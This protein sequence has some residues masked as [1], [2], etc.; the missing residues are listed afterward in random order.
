MINRESRDVLAECVRLYLVGEVSPEELYDLADRYLTCND[1]AIENFAEFLTFDIFEQGLGFAPCEFSKSVWD[2]IQRYLL[3]LD[4]DFQ[5]QE[6]STFIWTR[7]QLVAVLALLLFSILTT[8]IG[9]AAVLIW[10]SVPF[11][12]LSWYIS[13]KKQ[14]KIPDVPYQD[15]LRPFDSFASLNAALQQV[16]Q[17]FGFEEMRYQSNNITR[18]SLVRNIVKINGLLSLCFL[19]SILLLPLQI[20]P[21]HYVERKVVSA[22]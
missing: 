1:V 22:I 3:L 9:L 20:L 15:I 2:T 16:E 13:K 11:A 14:E 10:L 5:I 19:P 17:K 7:W 8:A 21:I 4:S 12:A 6:S 18:K